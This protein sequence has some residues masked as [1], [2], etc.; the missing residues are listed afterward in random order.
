[1]KVGVA[2]VTLTG[3][4]TAE[5][6]AAALARA[7]HAHKVQGVEQFASNPTSGHFVGRLY[8][9]T[10]TEVLMVCIDA[11]G[12]Y[13]P[14]AATNAAAAGQFLNFFGGL[15]VWAQPFEIQQLVSSTTTIPLGTTDTL[16]WSASLTLPAGW[17]TFDALIWGHCLV[18]ENSEAN[19]RADVWLESPDGTLLG[20]KSRTAWEHVGS[21]FTHENQVPLLGLLTGVAASQAVRAEGVTVTG[22]ANATE[23]DEHFAVAF[24]IRKT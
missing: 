11:G 15:P 3:N 5:G 21:G 10:T 19:A 9:N 23:A 8:F 1:V 17:T 16:I 14:A 13:V 6:V 22:A 4:V 24:K 20:Q 7:D 12:T 2:P 18:R